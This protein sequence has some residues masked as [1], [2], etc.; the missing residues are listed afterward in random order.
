[1]FQVNT[2]IQAQ[3]SLRNLKKTQEKLSS[4]QER[5][6]TGKRINKASDDAAGA[7][8]ASTLEA[9]IGGQK[10]AIRNIGDTKSLLRTAEGGLTS[11]LDILKTMREKVVQAAN[12]ALSDADE[13][14]IQNELNRLTREV[15]EIAEN[16]TFNGKSLLNGTEG[17]SLKKTFSFQ[18][19]ADPGDQFDVSFGSFGARGSKS[20]SE[21]PGSTPLNIGTDAR[22]LV[23]FD[24][25]GNAI[26]EGLSDT[27]DQNGAKNVSVSPRDF[28]AVNDDSYQRGLRE[29]GGLTTFFGDGDRDPLKDSVVDAGGDPTDGSAEGNNVLLSTGA[30]RT[31]T[32]SLKNL[33]GGTFNLTVEQT[34]SDEFKVQVDRDGVPDSTIK[35]GVRDPKPDQPTAAFTMSGGDEVGE[36]VTFDASGSSDPETDIDEYRWDFDG[37][38]DAEKTTAS[39]TTTFEF[40]EAGEKEV[41]LTVVDDGEDPDSAR[42]MKDFTTETRQIEK[43]DQ[44]KADFDVTGPSNPEVGD[45]I[46]FDASGSSHPDP[47]NNID[48]YQW[49]FDGDGTAEATGETVTKSF[50]T[51][52]DKEVALTVVDDTGNPEGK[53]FSTETVTVEK[54]DP[55]DST[56]DVS[57]PADPNYTYSESDVSAPTDPGYTEQPYEP[58]AVV[59]GNDNIDSGQ[60]PG[61]RGINTD[62]TG[63][64]LEGDPGNGEALK[65]DLRYTE[66]SV[67]T[68]ATGGVGGTGEFSVTVGGEEDILFKND[69]TQDGGARAGIDRI[70]NAIDKVTSKLSD[71]GTKL[72]R[73]SFKEENLETTRTNVQASQ[74]QIEDADFAR[75][76]AQAAKMQIKQQFGVAQLAQANADPRSVLS[77]L[78][79]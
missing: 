75:T 11:Q 15:Q 26:K 55:S 17:D 39:A 58:R 29:R 48:E 68:N 79:G 71:L 38:G 3:R 12:G 18:T 66:K 63:I 51:A 56:N 33:D 1:M 7:R 53:D 64:L 62:D 45:D 32:G 61:N 20:L 52:G 5:L 6:T 36:E 9:K 13:E 25:D 41:A 78:G 24:D 8:I 60:R 72:N 10:Q 14:A 19:G 4:H 23:E 34:G 49:D 46:T 47:E 54:S 21:T 31:D 50:G 42:A 35:T 74:S 69:V 67:L 70:D 40:D 16:T 59:G 77:L 28:G 65:L 37:D 2:N 43:P 57:A 76:Q 27:P 44:P 73:L 30:P 22:P